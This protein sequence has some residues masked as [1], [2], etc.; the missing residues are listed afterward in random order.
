MNN[1][2]RKRLRAWIQQAREIISRLEAIESD[3]EMVYDNMPEG[4]QNSTN[5][6]NSEEAIEKMNEAIECMEE[7]VDCIE[8]IL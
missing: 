7:A 4:L 8:E 5:G 6:L 1:N 2:Q 3:E